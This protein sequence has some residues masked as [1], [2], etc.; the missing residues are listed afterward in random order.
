MHHNSAAWV[1]V[2]ILSDPSNHGAC[3]VLPSRVH[4]FDHFERIQLDNLP[5][6][7]V[8]LRFHPASIPDTRNLM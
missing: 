8:T 6:P 5:T 1:V 3:P 2:E 4:R 7:D